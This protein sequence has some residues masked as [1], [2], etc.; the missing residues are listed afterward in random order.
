MGK[1]RSEIE[2]KSGTSNAVM[3]PLLL[4]GSITWPLTGTEE[5]RLGAFEM[6]LLR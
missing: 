2:D 3:L 1:D 5:E 6:R 4:Y